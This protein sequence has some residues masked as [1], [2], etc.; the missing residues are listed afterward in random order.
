MEDKPKH[1]EAGV[2]PYT[3][4]KA[5]KKAV[6]EKQDLAELRNKVNAVSAHDMKQAKIL[7]KPTVPGAHKNLARP[8]APA[9]EKDSLKLMAE[10]DRAKLRKREHKSLMKSLTL[11]QM[12]TASM[13]KFD[14]KLKK[15]PEAPKSQKIER[16]KSN[17]KLWEVS[18]NKNKEKERNMKIFETM[19]RK[20]EQKAGGKANANLDENKMVKRVAKKEQNKRRKTAAME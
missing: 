8:T 16:K 13:G 15:E 20:S 6:L 10:Q 7:T 4:A 3:W 17:A 9:T 1:L 11:A 12:S 2:D 18:E 14:K 5:E 19:Q